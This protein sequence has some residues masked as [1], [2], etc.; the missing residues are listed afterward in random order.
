M[1]APNRYVLTPVHRASYLWVVF[2]VTQLGYRLFEGNAL[3]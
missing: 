2:R 1:S 3:L